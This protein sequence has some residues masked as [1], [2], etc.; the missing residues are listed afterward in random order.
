MAIKNFRTGGKIYASGIRVK[1]SHEE[2]RFLEATLQE[3]LSYDIIEILKISDRL[4][5]WVE[6][7]F[8]KSCFAEI[9][10]QQALSNETMK[11]LELHDRLDK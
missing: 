6:W 2:S 1:W 5:K 10:P 9:T 11:M 8:E 7:D 4:D 3:S